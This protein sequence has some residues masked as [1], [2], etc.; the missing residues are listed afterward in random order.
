MSD[1]VDRGLNRGGKMVLTIL[2]LAFVLLA[3]SWWISPPPERYAAAQFTPAEKR[4]IEQRHKYHGIYGSIR[5]ES[6]H[7]FYR[8]GKK[9]KL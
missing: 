8:E 1:Q 9:C 7:Y 3:R 2:L 5:D 4:W 6:G